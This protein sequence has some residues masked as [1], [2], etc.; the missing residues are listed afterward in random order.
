MKEADRKQTAE[1]LNNEKMASKDKQVDLSKEMAEMEEEH[2]KQTEQ[3]NNEI[4]ASKDTITSLQQKLKDLN[5]EYKDAKVHMADRGIRDEGTLKKLTKVSADQ[6]KTIQSLEVELS[7]ITEEKRKLEEDF[8]TTKDNFKKNVERWTKS[9]EELKL[10]IS[11]ISTSCNECQKHVETL[12]AEN[13][14]L[15]AHLLETEESFR[16]NECELSSEIT[17]LRASLDETSQV[18]YQRTEE[19]VSLVALYKGVLSTNGQ[20]QGQVNQYQAQVQMKEDAKEKTEKQLAYL[21]D[22]MDFFARRAESFEH[23]NRELTK[24]V[25]QASR[26]YS[27][28]KHITEITESSLSKHKSFLRKY[29]RENIGY[30][31]TICRLREK[32][33]KL[34]DH[35]SSQKL[36]LQEFMQSRLL[37]SRKFCGC[38]RDLGISTICFTYTRGLFQTPGGW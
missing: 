5:E 25:S 27:E 38:H 6:D 7:K 14:E 3:L 29:I 32:I 31:E 16:V 20:L 22:R 35:F 34:T 30:K 26:N 1:Q 13:E 12:Q 17:D 21:K 9:E 15:T 8:N 24:D 10:Q 11:K 36:L 18:L 23:K 4:E 37:G 19:L 28:S 33:K 2:R